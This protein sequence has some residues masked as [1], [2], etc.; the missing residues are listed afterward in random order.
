LSAAAIIV[1]AGPG[2]EDRMRRGSYVELRERERRE[3]RSNRQQ[4]ED[5][6]YLPEFLQ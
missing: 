6:G 2:K 5:G 4:P 1:E 3:K